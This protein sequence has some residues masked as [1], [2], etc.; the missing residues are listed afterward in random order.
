[1]VENAAQHTLDWYRARLGNITGSMVGVLMKEGRG[2][3]FTDAARTYLYQL[4]AERMMNPAIVDDDEWF[5]D[6]IRQTGAPTPAMRWGT[7]KE[8]EARDLYASLYKAHVVEL[9]SCRHPSIPRFAS[10]PDGFSYDE[11]S[12]IKTCLEIKCPIQSTFMRYVHEVRDNAT[13]LRAKPEYFYQCMAHMMVTNA[14]QTDFIVYCPWQLNP[15]H[16]SRITAD[17]AVFSKMEKRIGLA[18]AFID[19]ITSNLKGQTYEQQLF[20]ETEPA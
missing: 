4:A 6:Y 10:S 9:G 18:N 13:L 3:T 5:E 7:E 12:G 2:D 17:E 19:S 15:L 11:D 1:M 8:E 20:R 14:A 16:V